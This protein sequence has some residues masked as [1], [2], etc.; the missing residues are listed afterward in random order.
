[1]EFVRKNVKVCTIFSENGEIVPKALWFGGEYFEITAVLSV[2]KKC[3]MSVGC[4]APF[5]FTVRISGSEKK[6][7]YEKS[8]DLWFVAAKIENEK[9]SA[10]VLK[11]ENATRQ[12]NTSQRS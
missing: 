12:S 1:M 7:Y 2:R 3:P 9:E 8:T 11:T 6:I 5:E 4:I 10:E